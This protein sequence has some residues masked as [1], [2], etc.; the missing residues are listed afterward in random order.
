MREETRP[1]R[2]LAA[3][4]AARPGA[5]EEAAVRAATRDSVFRPEPAVEQETFALYA[6]DTP[7]T[8]RLTLHADA[9][10]LGPD[11]VR[12]VLFGIERLLVE[13]AF[14]DVR[15]AEVAELTGLAG[16]GAGEP[17]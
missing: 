4:R 15:P 17:G 2:R 10:H 3:H 7:E 1:D 9:R 13:S 12:G 8:L 5:A 11:A 14:G 16:P 6:E